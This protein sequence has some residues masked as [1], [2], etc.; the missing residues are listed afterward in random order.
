MKTQTTT[1]MPDLSTLS[2][3]ERWRRGLKALATVIADPEQTDQVLVFSA[4]VNGAN[5][6]RMDRFFADPNGQR[7]YAEHRTIDSHTVNLDA[8]AQLPDGTLGREYARFLQSRGFTPDVFEGAPEGVTDPRASYVVQRLRQTHDLWHV[9][10]GS[11]TDPASEVAL[12]AFT[13][14]QVGAPSAL[15]LTIAGTL[16]AFRYKPAIVRDVVAMYRTGR[17]AEKLAVFPWEDH[18]ATPL[19]ELRAMLALPLAPH[20]AAA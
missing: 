19:T 14:A 2:A 13:Y 7:L 15:I 6:E 3:L 12:Q 4:Y 1:A 17:E 10:T 18:W 20:A 5:A 11:E 9:M 16:R 8:L